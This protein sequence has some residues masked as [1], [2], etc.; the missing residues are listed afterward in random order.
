MY[1]V[2]A[3][4]KA[5]YDKS[6]ILLL[7]GGRGSGKSYFAAQKVVIRCVSES[8]HKFLVI[9][10]YSN[11]I[12]GSVYEQ[13][14][15]V[16]YD[17]GFENDFIFN[18]TTL[19][20]KH[21][22]TGSRIVFHGLDD[23]EKLKSI[24]GITGIWIEEAT[25]V[26]E[27]DFSQLDLSFRGITKY[28][29]QTIL[30]FNP[31]DINHWINKQFFI[32]KEY[33]CSSYHTTFRDNPYVDIEKYEKKLEKY[34]SDPNRY[35]IAALGQWGQLTDTIIFTNW[36]EKDI[37]T[38][39][40]NYEQVKAGADFGWKHASTCLLVAE[41]GDCLFILKEIYKSGLTYEAFIDNIKTI[42][43]NDII[44]TADSAEPRGIQMIRNA[45]LKVI[46]A[47]K[48]KG[49]VKDA[50][51][52]LKTKKIIIHPSCKQTIAEIEAYSYKYDAK[53]DTIF[54]EPAVQTDDAM[55]ALRYSVNDRLKDRSIKFLPSI[56]I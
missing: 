32:K 41:K 22:K 38:D 26:S 29:Q 44:I 5:F 43:P 37:S 21:K 3:Y 42:V 19:E 35:K 51:D 20:I 40:N 7:W 39:L 33:K 24:T 2:P 28:Y 48:Y 45:G 50:I 18:K 54:D 53:T 23:G 47:K 55:A 46:S 8:N 34:K 27:E 30:S 31:I 4:E 15:K 14:E 10:R 11:K 12:R 6:E 49:S 16:I 52:Y 56:T 1:V 25:E 13:I 17:L 36:E 9:R